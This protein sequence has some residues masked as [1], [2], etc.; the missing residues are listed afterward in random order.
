MEQMLSSMLQLV[1]VYST[2]LP[3]TNIHLPNEAPGG[4]STTSHVNHDSAIQQPK[5]EQARDDSYALRQ[6]VQSVLRRTFELER[7]MGI[8]RSDRSVRR[9]R[10]Q[11]GLEIVV[12]D[13]RVR[14][15]GL[16]FLII[17]FAIIA[18]MMVSNAYKY[19]FST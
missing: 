8:V 3:L 17:I 6:E 1:C 19:A 12:A 5:S 4:G 13:N 18:I 11:L 2:S 10:I 7:R 14:A 16:P 9:E 15:C